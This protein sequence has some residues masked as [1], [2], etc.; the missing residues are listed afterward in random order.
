MSVPALLVATTVHNVAGDQPEAP[1]RLMHSVAQNGQ[2]FNTPELAIAYQPTDW[3]FANHSRTQLKLPD[4]DW[5]L[6]G[7]SFAEARLTSVN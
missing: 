1:H 4:L 5:V 2:R 3:P 6:H 7:F